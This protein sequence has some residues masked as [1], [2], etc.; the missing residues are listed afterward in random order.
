MYFRFIALE[1]SDEGILEGEQLDEALQCF[2][3]NEEEM[4]EDQLR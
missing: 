3:K 2:T 4:T 1:Q